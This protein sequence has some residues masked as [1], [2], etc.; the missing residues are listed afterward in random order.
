LQASGLVLVHPGEE[1]ALLIVGHARALHPR[2]G[3]RVT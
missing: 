1:L 2:H 3:W